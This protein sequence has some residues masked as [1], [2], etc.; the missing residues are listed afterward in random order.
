MIFDMNA[1]KFPSLCFTYITMVILL[2]SGCARVLPYERG[3]LARKCMQ[4][5]FSR[6]ELRNDY[7]NK[8]Q[9]TATASELPGGTP[10]GGCGCTQ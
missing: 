10:G 4:S 3:D 5:P 6:M 2:L 8:V 7:E 9:Q 1:C